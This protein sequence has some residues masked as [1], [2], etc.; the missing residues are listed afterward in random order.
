MSNRQPVSHPEETNQIAMIQS[1]TQ[2]NKRFTNV[3]GLMTGRAGS[4]GF[5]AGIAVAIVPEGVGLSG[6]T[7]A[8]E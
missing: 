1:S 7:L 5:S 3:P 4:V 8:K 2:E 6:G